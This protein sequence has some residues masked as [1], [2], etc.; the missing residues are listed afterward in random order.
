MTA[1]GALQ[2][3][4]IQNPAEFRQLVKTRLM[5]L[6]ICT[7]SASR[8]AVVSRASVAKLH[9]ASGTSDCSRSKRNETHRALRPKSFRGHLH[10][11]CAS[12]KI[13]YV[14][15]PRADMCT[16]HPCDFQEPRCL[17]RSVRSTFRARIALRECNCSDSCDSL[18]RCDGVFEKPR[19]R[20]PRPM[21]LWCD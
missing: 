6:C 10:M 21:S 3:C 20:L 18:R 19:E 2:V 8:I 13:S 4:D 15:Y 7:R 11:G 1:S 14:R 12:Q 5:S 16:A 9:R 17:V